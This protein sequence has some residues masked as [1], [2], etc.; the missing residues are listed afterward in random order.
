MANKIKKKEEVRE[1]L[2]WVCLHQ[3]LLI[4][5][6]QYLKFESNF[7]YLDGN[8]VH[9]KTVAGGEDALGILQVSNLDLRFPY[10]MN[11]IDAS[12]KFIGLGNHGGS[13]TIRFTFPSSLAVQDDR[14]SARIS[15]LG[16]GYATFNL[17]SKVFIRANLID[18]S[19]TGVRM[20]S[21]ADLS[22]NKLKVNERIM[23]SIHLPDD[24]SINTGAIVRHVEY[25]TFGAEFSPD[26]PD[27]VL[28]ALSNWAFKRQEEGQEQQS[29]REDLSDQ[30]AAAMATSLNKKP[31]DGSGVVVITRDDEMDSTLSK[32]LSEGRS[33]YRIPPAMILMD[34]AMS[35]RPNLVIFHVDNDHF[36]ERLLMRSLAQTVPPSTPILFLGTNID[37]ESLA[38]LS[39][40]CKAVT[41]LMWTPGKSIFLQRLALGITRKFYGHSQGPIVPRDE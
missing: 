9:A 12:A 30:A 1:I 19:P 24:L 37:P 28:S 6:T 25:R 18:I 36:A 38:E 33:Y 41:S 8:E 23:L 29:E 16:G 2:E 21:N 20:V 4:I 17:A 39:Q 22:A 13:K 40:T 26:L 11:F 35:R 5:S 14:Y 7:V 31:G 27:S 34:Y 32:L 3:A 10:K 15:D